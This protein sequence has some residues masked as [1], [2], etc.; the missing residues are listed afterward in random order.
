MNKNKVLKFIYA[1]V[2]TICIAFIARNV[3][4][5]EVVDVS[6]A[7]KN[8]AKIENATNEAISPLIS[9]YSDTPVSGTLVENK[10]NAA[11]IYLQK[12]GKNYTY[13]AQTGNYIRIFRYCYETN[14]Y[15]RVY[16]EPTN[17]VLGTKVE[18][19]IIYFCISPSPTEN[20]IVKA[21]DTVTETFVSTTTL[22]VNESE[23]K[24]GFGVDSNQNYYL[25]LNGSE[26]NQLSITSFNKNGDEID[27]I[28]GTMDPAQLGQPGLYNSF[29]FF[30]TNKDN[31]VLF[32]SGW[33]YYGGQS[34]YNDFL[35][36]MNNGQ[37]EQDIY[38]IRTEGGMDYRFL[39]D[40][41]TLAY[42]QYG[43]ILE[44][45]YNST[46]SFGVM[47]KV[48]KNINPDIYT[49]RTYTSSINDGTYVYIGF[50][51]G[52]LYKYN[53]R[54]NLID[55]YIDLGSD[56]YITYACSIGNSQVLVEYKSNGNFY[57][58]ILNESEFTPTLKN[59][60]LSIDHVA[61]SHTKVQIKEM[62]DKAKTKVTNGDYYK[63]MPNVQA[64]HKAGA[65]K[66]EVLTDILNQLNYFR[67]LTGLNGVN[68]NR[69]Y[70][71]QSQKGSVLLAAST[72]FAHAP[73]RP[74]DMD[75]EFYDAAVAATNAGFGF[76]ANISSGDTPAGSVKGYIDDV[77]NIFP[78]VGHRLSLLDF[79]A[80]DASFGY[81]KTK[82]V[83][84][85]FRGTANNNEVYYSWPACGYFPIN[86]MDPN[87][88][89]SVSIN[90]DQ[91]EVTSLA[92][93]I[94]RANGKEYVIS[95]EDLFVDEDYN[96]YYYNIPD[97]LKNYLTNNTR[98][99]VDGK[100]VEVEFKG[101]ADTM[102]NTY[103]IKYP[104][105]FF[106]LDNTKEAIFFEESKYE[107]VKGS[108]KLPTLK[109][110]SGRTVTEKIDFKSSDSNVITIN[111]DGSLKAIK[112]GKAT[113]TATVNGVSTTCE[114]EVLDY[115]K[116]DLDKNGIINGA[117][118]SVAL[119]IYNKDI[120]TEESLL[121]GDMDNN[122]LINGADAS[123]ILD[124]YNKVL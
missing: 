29:D 86:A 105:R 104:V 82:S 113:I 64:P 116:G 61:L 72:E 19:N 6:D 117:D 103:M 90:S 80:T 97:E 49:F 67:W 76:S 39:N 106:S 44:I 95:P 118:A 107:L 47:I 57:T 27:Q 15:E 75:Q 8:G 23:F 26:D 71:E 40:E 25:G 108:S 36:K 83:I 50:T 48:I 63:E 98:S 31:T 124:I 102:G 11:N 53:F 73:A 54:T 68:I 42:D 114:F 88:M 35:I 99:F 115:L 32:F 81:S 5:A 52:M 18:G 70:I 51:G 77:Y 30:N 119:D 111:S 122:G 62:Y 24:S 17:L 121:I 21:Y 55:K 112:K 91:Y 16:Y 69:A 85:M 22:P 41:K 38:C 2:L 56:K 94:I 60:L 34:W 101:I 96:S 109:Y 13:S 20:I 28:T 89:W 65:L 78:N 45:D 12:D 7:F 4:A 10:V 120:T 100:K 74:S 46:E 87:A 93:I 33:I 14:Q 58:T 84:N 66:E 3:Y 1:V 79:M 59:V 123:M 37:F 92:E 9:F 110:E 43:E